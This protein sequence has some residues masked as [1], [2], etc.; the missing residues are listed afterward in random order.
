VKLKEVESVPLAYLS[1]VRNSGRRS[2][3]PSEPFEG[4]GALEEEGSEF[5]D[6]PGHTRQTMKLPRLTIITPSLNQGRYLERTLRSVLDQGYPDLE[7]IVIDGGSTDESVSILRRFDSRLAYWVSEPDHGQAHAVNRGI[8]RSTGDVVAYI[9][10]DDWYEPGALATVARMFAQDTSVRWVAGTCRYVNA[11]GSLHSVV[12]PSLPTGLRP[13]W[14]RLSW[15]VPQASSFWRRDVFDEFGLL[16]EDL[17]YVFDTEFGLRVALG[18][19]L[20]RIVNDELAVRFLHDE[21]KSA[22]RDRFVAE[23]EL[24]WRQL[25]NDLPKIERAAEAVLFSLRHANNLNPLW[26]QYR[27]RR[28]LGLLSLRERLSRRIQL[29]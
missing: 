2:I 10:S 23:H 7:Y 1:T 21:A 20:P 26:L 14:P 24:V 29:R 19:V 6:R 15:Y 17:Q 18:G 9:N 4:V 8:A 13:R 22:Y 28:R 12:K 3:R 27:I 5:R 25:R 11:D 16:R